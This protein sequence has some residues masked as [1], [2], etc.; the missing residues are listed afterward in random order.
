[1]ATPRKENPQPGGRPPIYNKAIHAK[2]VRALIEHGMTEPEA[3]AFFEVSLSC[4]EKW[5]QDHPEFLREIDKARELPVTMSRK[6]YTRA[7]GYKYKEVKSEISPAI[8]VEQ[9]VPDPSDPNKFM[10]VK[11]TLPE[12]ELSRVETTKYMPPDVNALKFV[13]TNRD[14]KRWQESAHLDMTSGGDKIG[15]DMDLSLLT[16]EEVAILAA[17]ERKAKGL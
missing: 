16:D 2:K 5:K 15:K 9:S 14:K 13:L 17:L 4:F 10:I 8:E 3:A 12:R 11:V 1:M 6:L 7:K